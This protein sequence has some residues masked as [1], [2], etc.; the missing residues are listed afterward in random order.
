MFERVIYK[1]LE[2]GFTRLNGNSDEL[3]RLFKMTQPYVTDKET[4]KILSATKTPPSII[5][6]YPRD[7][8]KFPLLAIILRNEAES[9]SLV[10]DQAGIVSEADLSDIELL[11][12]HS[13][14]SITQD[15]RWLSTFFTYDYSI[16]VM[17]KNVDWTIYTY[18]VAKYLLFASRPAFK[19][20][21]AYNLRLS[22]S[23]LEPKME[24]L[25]PYIFGRQI[26]LSLRRE[27]K[28]IDPQIPANI[29]EEV[30]TDVTGVN[31]LA[32]HADVEV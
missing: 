17:S 23:D 24:Y 25:P 19:Q 15:H 9:Q 31:G 13:L 2:D 14:G 4:S 20:Y 21:G 30:E 22:G 7:D 1:I 16:L 26:N 5:H 32:Y 11:G 12:G 27:F 3:T 8:S 18:E 10:G 29:V 28:I 6:S